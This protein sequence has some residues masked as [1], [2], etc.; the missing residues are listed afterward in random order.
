MPKLLS[1]PSCGH[2]RSWSLRRHHRR[3]KRCRTEWSPRSFYPV[4]G[5]RLSRREWL[6]IIETFIRDETINAVQE[7][8]HLA[9]GTA[10]K[11]VSLI[12]LVMTADVPELFFGT[13]EADETYIGGD[14]KNKKIHIRRQGTKRGRGTSKQPIFG[15]ILRSDEEN[16]K[17]RVWLTPNTKNRNLNGRIKSLVVRGSTIYTDGRKGYRILPRHGYLHDWVDHEAGEYIRG[18]VH[19]QN[20]DGFWGRLKTRLDSI[21]GVKRERLHLFVGEYVWCFNFRHLTRKEQT[22]RIYKLL[23]EIGGRK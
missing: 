17:V 1:C 12:R 9:R 21:G 15:V 22:K 2:T 23:T 8:C 20:I 16:S 3:C 14:W 7:E 10:S 11:A 13:C 5:F 19:T 18:K 4:C 6:L